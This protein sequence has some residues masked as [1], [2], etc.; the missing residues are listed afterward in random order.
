MGP[1]FRW[2]RA[3]WVGTACERADLCVYLLASGRNGTLYVGSTVDLLG[4]VREHRDHVFAGFTK[5]Y[6]VTRLVWF[7]AQGHG[8]A[9]GRSRLGSVSGRSICSKRPTRTGMISIQR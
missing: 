5:K 7:E 3:W 1:G 6:G 4:R 9:S 8:I 2:E